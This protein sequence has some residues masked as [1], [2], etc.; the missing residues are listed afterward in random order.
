MQAL[1]ESLFYDVRSSYHCSL[2]HTYTFIKVSR[3]YVLEFTNSRRALWQDH[4]TWHSNIQDQL[5]RSAGVSHKPSLKK[6]G[7]SHFGSKT[8]AIDTVAG[9]VSRLRIHDSHEDKQK[10]QQRINDVRI[11][12]KFS[13]PSPKEDASN[14]SLTDDQIEQSLKRIIDDFTP[15]EGDGREKVRNGPPLK[16]PDCDYLFHSL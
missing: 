4:Y 14:A 13:K 11:G 5:H 15:Y 12:K 2:Q 9:L 1:R 16:C 3:L 10:G 6:P 7:Q 8:E